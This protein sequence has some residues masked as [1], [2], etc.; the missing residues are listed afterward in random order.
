M[1]LFCYKSEWGESDVIEKVSD[2]LSSTTLTLQKIIICRERNMLSAVQH[3]MRGW[4]DVCHHEH[5]HI[6]E[7]QN[8]V[9][10]LFYH[11][12][13]LNSLFLFL[14]MMMMIREEDWRAKNHSNIFFVFLMLMLFVLEKMIFFVLILFNVMLRSFFFLIL[15]IHM[16]I[17]LI[18]DWSA[19][20]CVKIICCVFVLFVILLFALNFSSL[21]KWTDEILKYYEIQFSYFIMLYFVYI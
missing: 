2:F 21:S 7:T 11:P 9:F 17:S 13:M 8:L 5:S 1:Y 20:Q 19:F 4:V 15:R 14:S 10:L 12:I 18:C 16:R 3:K 6:L